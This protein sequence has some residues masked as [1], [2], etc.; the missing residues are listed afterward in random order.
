MRQI[1]FRLFYITKVNFPAKAF[2]VVLNNRF[3]FFM[4]LNQ[5]KYIIFVSR[6]KTIHYIF[7]IALIPGIS[8]LS[9]S[10]VGGHIQVGFLGSSLSMHVPPFK[11]G[12]GKQG[13]TEIL[14]IVYSVK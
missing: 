2:E 11:Q 10:N 8:H 7:T 4:L 5:S 9:P 1:I 13:A 12:F 6:F 14:N 3:S